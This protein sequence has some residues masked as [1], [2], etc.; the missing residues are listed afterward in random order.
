MTVFVFTGPT[1]SAAD[2]REILD[3]HYLPP[4]AQGDVYALARDRPAA[5]GIIDG[6]FDHVPSVWHKEILWALSHGVHV[7]GA[8]SMGALRAAELEPFG[9]VG[10]GKIFKDFLSGTL[11]DDDEVA[12]VHGPAESGFLAGSEAMV[13]IRATLDAAVG[14]GILGPR[15]R[16]SLV[17]RTKSWHYASRNWSRLLGETGDTQD[18]SEEIRALEAWLPTGRVDQKRDDA[19]AMLR[20]MGELLETRPAAKDVAFTFHPTYVWEKL[21]RSVDGGT[22]LSPENTVG[23][24]T[25]GLLEEL[26]LRGDPYHVERE[27][28]L[29]RLLSLEVA[30]HRGVEVDRATSR[31]EFDRGMD[32]RSRESGAGARLVRDNSLVERIRAISEQRLEPHFRDHLE[33]RGEA[34]G[35]R[36]RAVAK[37]K[38]LAR[39][40]LDN[41]SLADVDIEERE[42]WRWYFRDSLD[43]EPEQDL[44]A[45]A[46]SLDLENAGELRRAVLREYCYRQLGREP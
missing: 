27:R 35:L 33:V 5:I 14:A 11:E 7:F 25:S 9:M 45:W 28:A 15:T 43:R 8:S 39:V 20:A 38:A 31:S 40:G 12:V 34:T 42:L 3:A 13:N 32:G 37:Q 16:D 21:R 30:R 17:A 29:V 6:F 19:V 10:V 1:L 44:D 36:E 24:G 41:P 2:G 46:T 18:C 23:N 4:A 22:A 26:R